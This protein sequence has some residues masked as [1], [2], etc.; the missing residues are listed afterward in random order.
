MRNAFTGYTYQKHVT[1]LFLSMMDVERKI[2]KIE[3]EADVNNNF[4]DIVVFTNNKSYYFQI[5]DFEEITLNDIRI[6]NKSISIK[7]K[8]HILPSSNTVIFIK[9][10]SI[11]SNCKILGI[12]CF[13]KD[14]VYFIS[15]NRSEIDSLILTLYKENLNR[16][17]E[18]EGFLSQKL[19]NRDWIINRIDLPTLKIFNTD[20]QEDTISINHNL[21]KFNNLQ[22]IE[23]KPGIGKSHFVETLAKKYSKKILYRF[24]ISNQDK[25]YKERLKFSSFIQDLNIKLFNDLKDRPHN[26]LFKELEEGNFTFI[27]DGL[28]HIENYNDEDFNSYINFIECLQNYCQVI[29]LS[30]PLSKIL[31]W[32]KI[33]LE[34]WNS[35]Q[36]HKVLNQLYHIDDYSIRE[37][38]F[39]LSNGYPIIVKYIAEYFRLNRK[40]PIYSQLNNLDNYYQEIL[41]KEKGK[42]ALSLFLCTNSFLM[43]TEIE[44]FLGDA[45]IYVEE[46]ISEHP[47]LFDFKLNRISLFH[48]SLNTYLRLNKSINYN[49]LDERTQNIVYTS[50]MNLEKRFLS[51]ISMFHLN[52]QQKNEILQKYF[53]MDVFEKLISN[54]IDIESIQSFYFQLRDILKDVNPQNLNPNHFYDFSLILC[55]LQRDHISSINSFLYTYI[56]SVLFNGFSEE[57]ITSSDYLFSMLFFI[58]T[59]NPTLLYNIT[60]NNNYST[61]FFHRDLDNA[62]IEEN[63]YFI[64]HNKPILKSELVKLLN[65]NDYYFRDNLVFILENLY[66]HNR[67]YKGYELLNESLRLYINGFESRGEILLAE[68]LSDYNTYHKPIWFLKDVKNNLESYGYEF[69]NKINQYNC[70]TLE[71]LISENR[72]E[73]SFNLSVKIHEYLRLNLNRGKKIDIQS[74]SKF[75]TKYYNRKDYTLY[76]I[77]IVLKIMEENKFISLVNC[78]KLISNIQNV[79]E[80]GYRYTLG[81]F[82]E[83]Y[84]PSHIIPFIEKEFDLYDLSLQWF[85]LP[86]EY[87]NAFSDRLYNH[88]LNKITEINRSGSIELNDIE[89]ALYSN[90]VED[91]AITFSIIKLKIRLIESNPIIKLLR[92]RKISFIENKKEKYNYS[93]ED[94][95]KEGIFYKEDFQRIKSNKLTPQDVAALSDGNYSCLS[96][97]SV[98]EIFEKNEISKNFNEIIFIALTTKTKRIDYYYSIY[99]VP[100][101][102]L[103]MIDKYR[104]KEE[105]YLAIKSFKKF[106]KLCHFNI[107]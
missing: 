59:K 12:E 82:I 52:N 63:N 7:G 38:I 48:D 100:G 35:E 30:R 94:N 92:K 8:E 3:I 90:R 101:N 57:D 77:P 26:I 27:I 34:N 78:I 71:E 11:T 61:D 21:I 2:A 46:F 20:L 73:G 4:D 91:I 24:W 50:I 107:D 98:F 42:Q 103:S 95:L 13:K 37:S 23:G 6:N 62:I 105:L 75:W 79:S 106:I 60:S 58:K 85:L 64:K 70:F 67:K 89:N 45:K 56:N 25:D 96:D 97:I 74:I 54:V 81:E 31:N 43:E 51:R 69:E 32:N 22:L 104:T 17:Y 84:E 68:F 44:L 9:K 40:M 18:I 41:K 87:I 15:K 102:M 28:D 80:K 53:S 39:N 49:Q 86:T 65:D 99:D 66:I 29:V 36:T 1:Q 10:I 14:G 93:N 76:S 55:L 88:A 83:F 5:K 19:D 47:Y 33:I 16:K 72:T